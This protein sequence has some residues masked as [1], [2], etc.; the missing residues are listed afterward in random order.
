MIG[1]DTN[2]LVRFVT[3]DE[4]RQSRRAAAAIRDAAESGEPLFVSAI[5]LCELVWVL[6][7]AYRHSRQEIGLVLDAV[8][9]TP[10]WAVEDRDLARLALGDYRAGIGDFADAFLGHRNR[11]T[12][13]SATLTFDRAFDRSILFRQL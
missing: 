2:V 9:E 10:E 4:P 13:C 12:G 8:I 6:R 5:V 3:H 1:L 11:S 7:R